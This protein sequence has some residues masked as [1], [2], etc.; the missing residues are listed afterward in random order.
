M[1]EKLPSMQRV[2][3]TFFCFAAVGQLRSLV[4]EMKRGISQMSAR[5]VKQLKRRERRIAKLKTNCDII[6]AIIQAS[7]PKR[8]KLSY[9]YLVR[10]NLTLKAPRKKKPSENVFC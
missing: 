8:S 7:S 3:T 9:M 10:H 6:T 4:N 5:L 1:Y 2:K